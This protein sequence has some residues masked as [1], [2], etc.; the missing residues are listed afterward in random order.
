MTLERGYWNVGS[1]IWTYLGAMG[2]FDG[3]GDDDDDEDDEEDD[4]ED[5]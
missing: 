1:D 4:E 3:P 2:N 5:L